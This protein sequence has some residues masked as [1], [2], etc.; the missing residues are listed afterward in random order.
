MVVI[1][2]D[3]DVVRQV[4]VIP[5]ANTVP[6]GWHLY[7]PVRE[8][9]PAVGQLFR[10]DLTTQPWLAAASGVPVDETAN[11]HYARMG[12]ERCAHFCG[13]MQCNGGVKGPE[14]G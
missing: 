4:A 1:T 5:G 10:P 8:A 2:D 6:T 11:C 14:H 13:A 9:V 12:K 3:Q 7:F